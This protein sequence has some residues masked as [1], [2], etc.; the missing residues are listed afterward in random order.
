MKKLTKTILRI[1]VAVAVIY[2]LTLLPIYIAIPVG[3]LLVI[4]G[5]AALVEKQERDYYDK[6]KELNNNRLEITLRERFYKDTK[7]TINNKTLF[8][9]WDK[10][11]SGCHEMN[12]KDD[13]ELRDVIVNN[14]EEIFPYSI[15]KKSD[16]DYILNIATIQNYSNFS[17]EGEW[18]MNLLKRQVDTFT[19]IIKLFMT[20]AMDG[21]LDEKLEIK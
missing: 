18:A 21:T 7:I 3:I 9:V 5:Y 11:F 1:I 13:N 19:P 14:A 6:L 15:E 16:E 2:L 10:F 12:F 4:I 20:Y 17:W 8:V